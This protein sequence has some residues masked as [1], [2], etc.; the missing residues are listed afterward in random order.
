MD[1]PKVWVLFAT[2]RRTVAAC[3]TIES[4]GHYLKY[5]NLHFHICDDGSGMADDGSERPH[6]DVLADKFREF[7]PEVTAH[8]MQ[9]P[10]GQFNTGGNINEGIRYAKE[11]GCDIHILIFDDWALFRE[12]DL[13]PH[14]D[15]LD[16]HPEVGF[17]RLSY[18][19]PGNAGVMM[20]YDL[21]RLGGEHMFFRL[22]REWSINNPWHTDTYTVSTQPYIAHRRFFDV[23]GYHPEHVNPGIAECNLGGQYNNSPLGENGPQILWYI[24]PGVVHAPWAHLVGRAHYYANF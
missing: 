1:W 16:N 21:P 15:V 11:A 22:I 14:V 19:V 7:Y 13:R 10:E 17:V 9:T 12:L 24:G 18:Y 20:G 23:Y 5:P 2:F 8:V 3:T 4:L 6:V